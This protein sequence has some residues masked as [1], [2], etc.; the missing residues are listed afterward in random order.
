MHLINRSK[1]QAPRDLIPTHSIFARLGPK[2]TRNKRYS[3]TGKYLGLS[4]PLPVIDPTVVA[5]V[6][7]AHARGKALRKPEAEVPFDMTRYRPLPHK[8]LVSRG[9]LITHQSGVAIPDDKQKAAPWWL[10]VAVGDAVTACGVGQRI[11]C[12]RGFRPKECWLGKKYYSCHE[13]AVVGIV[14]DAI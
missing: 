6:R 9:P 5:R 7:A 13:E 12:G 3:D 14:E 4:R 11:V 1:D 2:L 10:V 8:V